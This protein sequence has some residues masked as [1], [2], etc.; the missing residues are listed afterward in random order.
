MILWVIL[1]SK[2]TNLTALFNWYTLVKNTKILTLNK[3]QFFGFITREYLDQIRPVAARADD[4]AIL[5][6]SAGRVKSPIPAN[7]KP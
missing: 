6:F 1:K 4:W 3:L 7:T 5:S 2:H